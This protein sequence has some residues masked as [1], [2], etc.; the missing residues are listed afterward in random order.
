MYWLQEKQLAQD[1]RLFLP[2][3]LARRVLSASQHRRM[4]WLLSISYYFLSLLPQ[5]YLSQKQLDRLLQICQR[6]VLLD[7]TLADLPQE[8]SGLEAPTLAVCYLEMTC[9]WKE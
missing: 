4:E 3:V 5:Y 8:D 2:C 6:Q 1:W 7:W 9:L